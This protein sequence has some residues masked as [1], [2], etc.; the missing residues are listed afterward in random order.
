MER[1]EDPDAGLDEKTRRVRR[2]FR[3]MDL[4]GGGQVSAQELEL[5]LMGAGLV[6]D[7]DGARALMEIADTDH[8]G[9]VNLHEFER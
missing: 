4:D 2:L 1:G 8:S 7:E 5:G 9:D 3:S 6:A